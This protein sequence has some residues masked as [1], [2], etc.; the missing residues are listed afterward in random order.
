V[1][2]SL[3]EQHQDGGTDITSTTAPAVAT[4]SPAACAGPEAGTE[5]AGAKAWAEAT[6]SESA[7]AASA[8]ARPERALR[9]CVPGVMAPDIVTELA[10]GL[11]ALFVKGAA[12]LGRE[13]KARRP[14]FTCERPAHVGHACF[15]EWVVH[16]LISFLER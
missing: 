6:G 2:R 7:A 8:E 16:W 11:P 1:H 15:K 5:A 12:I 4:A 3:G 13:S 14:R 9:P 10:A